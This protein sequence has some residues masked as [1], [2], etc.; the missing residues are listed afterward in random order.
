MNPE[1]KVII[2]DEKDKLKDLLKLLDEQYDLVINKELIKLDKIAR[3][4]DEAA[5]ELAR[6]EIR[7]RKI[8]GSDTSMKQTIENCDDTSIKEAYEDI[9]STLKMIEIQKEANDILIKQKLF[10]TKKMINFIKPN[11]GVATYNSSGQVGK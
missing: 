3:D 5:K 2:F 10:F 4:L 9:K 6:I 1:L 8:M 11:K 7:R